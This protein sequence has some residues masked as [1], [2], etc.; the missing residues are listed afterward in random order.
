MSYEVKS[1]YL[2]DQMPYGGCAGGLTKSPRCRAALPQ[3][4]FANKCEYSVNYFSDNF[5]LYI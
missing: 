4:D 3:T 5:I 2:Y 1:I